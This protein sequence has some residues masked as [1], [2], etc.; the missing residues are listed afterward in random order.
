M[1]LLSQYHDLHSLHPPSP[2][3]YFYPNKF[4]SALYFTDAVIGA[5][6]RTSEESGVGLT[7]LIKQG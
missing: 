6:R 3:L 1:C 5:M 4:N 2:T 7:K